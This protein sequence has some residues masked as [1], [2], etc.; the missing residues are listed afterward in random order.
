[1]STPKERDSSQKAGLPPTQ[2]PPKGSNSLELKPLAYGEGTSCAG[3]PAFRPKRPMGRPRRVI[4][5]AL[6]SLNV[7]LTVACRDAI[8]ARAG[9]KRK[10][11]A[12][13]E[14]VDWAAQ[15][16]ALAGGRFREIEPEGP[17]EDTPANV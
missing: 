10:V 9:G 5:G 17:A 12:Y 15:K 1:M 3:Q 14:S 2:T 6:A 11:S 13:L 7:R 8:R 16:A 4:R